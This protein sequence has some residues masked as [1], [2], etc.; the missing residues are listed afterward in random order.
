MTEGQSETEGVGER[1]SETERERDTWGSGTD[2]MVHEHSTF[3]LDCVN[4]DRD[5]KPNAH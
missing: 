1:Q 4:G 2:E 3:V 5:Q